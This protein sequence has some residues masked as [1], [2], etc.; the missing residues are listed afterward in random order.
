MFVLN[1]P[2]IIMCYIRAAQSE[3]ML[4]MGGFQV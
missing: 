3:T 4:V 2:V 1:I